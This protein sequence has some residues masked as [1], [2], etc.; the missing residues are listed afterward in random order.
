MTLPVRETDSRLANSLQSLDLAKGSSI[1]FEGDR[2]TR[3]YEVVR[4]VVRT[5][6]FH[7]DG[8]RQLTGFFYAGDVFG[9]DEPRRTESAEAVTD[10]TLLRHEREPGS[11]TALR[12]ALD[13]A[14]RFIFLLGHR[15]AV[16]RL[17]AFLVM[18][19]NR[20]GV[21]E[22]C[23]VPMSRADIADHLGLTMHTV[24]RTMTDIARRKLIALDGPQVFRI[25]DPEGLRELA[26]ISEAE[27][28]LLHPSPTKPDGALK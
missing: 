5:C 25:V 16:E 6:R 1:Y 27:S 12:R 19:A 28:V 2:A 10:V 22:D 20:H 26:G 23:A 4:G 11:E 18:I 9:V 15:T 21:G 14:Q 24:S 7:A 3:W 17:A 8:H 13:S